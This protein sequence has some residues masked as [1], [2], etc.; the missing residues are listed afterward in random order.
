MSERTREVWENVSVAQDAPEMR[1]YVSRPDNQQRYP[2]LIIIH[3]AYGLDPH[4]EDLARRFAGEGY[5]AMAADLFST[6]PFGRT[7]RPDEIQ[8]ASRVT[9]S[10]PAERRRDP[11]AVAEA[12]SALPGE[13][14]SRMRDIVAWQTR[15]DISAT[16][17][18]LER[19]ME[20]IRQRPDV[21]GNVGMIGFCY[22]GG[23][24]SRVAFSGAP[25]D[26]GASFYG[27]NPP[28]D[29]VAKVR[30]PLLFMYGRRDPF[31]MP[32]VPALLGAVQGAD[33]P[34]A[35]RIY[36]D[37]GHAFFNDTRPEMYN[38]DAARDAWHATTQFLARHLHGSV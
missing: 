25:L 33:L 7:L 4:F 26:A 8:R 3:E 18:P 17:E 14:A 11:A 23:V 13:E 35:M 19:L 22:G 38:G 16:V 2:A 6:D 27:Q 5:I 31:I 30:A 32:Q 36:E 9:W 37:A 20:W 34:Y 24:V 10:I 1:A 15:R 28:L 12:L 21:T 29:Q